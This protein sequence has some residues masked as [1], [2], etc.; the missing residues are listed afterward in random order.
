MTVSMALALP[1]CVLGWG[2]AALAMAGALRRNRNHVVAI[3]AMA[4]R[5][6]S[7]S[8]DIFGAWCCVP[9]HDGRVG[10]VPL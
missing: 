10:G 3:A 2:W 6:W 4:R 8:L 9:G 1:S 7:I 5:E